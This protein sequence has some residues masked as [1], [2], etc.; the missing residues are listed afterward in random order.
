MVKKIFGKRLIDQSK[1]FYYFSHG[2]FTARL[3]K[4]GFSIAAEA[5]TGSCETSITEL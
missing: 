4:V 3:N 1:I 2:L 5:C